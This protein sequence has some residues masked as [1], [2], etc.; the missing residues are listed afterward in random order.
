M[1]RHY[2][3][4]VLIQSGT[5]Q[6]WADYDLFNIVTFRVGDRHY[7][8]QNEDGYEYYFPI[9]FTIIKEIDDIQ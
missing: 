8:L 2:H 4:K 3:I 1:V 5:N 6:V 9:N 7:Y